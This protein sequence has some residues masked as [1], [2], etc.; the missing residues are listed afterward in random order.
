MNDPTCKSCGKP[1]AEHLGLQGTCERLVQAQ[2]D[3]IELERLLQQERYQVEVYRKS[4]ADADNRATSLRITIQAFAM[5]LLSV[6]KVNTDEWMDYAAGAFNDLCE[7][8][9]DGDRFQFDGRDGLRK[10]NP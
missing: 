8:L 3:I 2:L 1:F 5:C 6:R 7:V 10:V 4:Y 9:G